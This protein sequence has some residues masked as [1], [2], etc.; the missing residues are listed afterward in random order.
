LSNFGNLCR[1]AAGIPHFD[2]I[3]SI[4]LDNSLQNRLAK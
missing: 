4:P 1:V 3:H 2:E